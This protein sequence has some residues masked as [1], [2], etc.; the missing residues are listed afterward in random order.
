[1]IGACLRVPIRTASDF[2]AAAI[3]KL[4]AYVGEQEGDTVDDA[5][6]KIGEYTLAMQEN[7]VDDFSQRRRRLANLETDLQAIIDAASAETASRAAIPEMR[8]LVDDIYRGAAR[9]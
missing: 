3:A 8:A 7:G 5:I 6:V 9:E 4:E 1:M 2:Y